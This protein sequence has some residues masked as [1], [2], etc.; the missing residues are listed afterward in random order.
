MDLYKIIDYFNSHDIDDIMQ[1]MNDNIHG[2]KPKLNIICSLYCTYYIDTNI[3]SLYTFYNIIKKLDCE[4]NK[5]KQQ[6]LLRDIYTHL[7][8]KSYKK[9]NIILDFDINDIHNLITLQNQNVLNDEYKNYC[10]EHTI[11]ILNIFLYSLLYENKQ[12]AILCVKYLLSKSNKELFL[13][14]KSKNDIIWII[15]TIMM[16]IETLPT[17]CSDYIGIAKDMFFYQLSKNNQSRIERLPTLFCSVLVCLTKSVKYKKVNIPLY[18]SNID[19][20][21]SYLYTYTEKN[22]DEYELISKLKE[23]KKKEK[24]YIKPRALL[25]D[26]KEYEKI[27]KL[28]EQLHIIR[29]NNIE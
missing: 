1:W 5:K 27:E 3:W 14:P 22:E 8:F 2:I 23:K 7:K 4:K 21:M 26:N 16:S 12:H 29:M 9:Y 19:D 15:F 24:H 17:K 11:S 10:T 25:I 18:M 28:R 20:R 13:D 6:E